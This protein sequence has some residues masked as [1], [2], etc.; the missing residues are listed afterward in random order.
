M[1]AAVEL[2][3]ATNGHRYPP[4]VI[5]HAM[6]KDAPWMLALK[7]LQPKIYSGAHADLER[8]SQRASDPFVED[9]GYPTVPRSAAGIEDE[10][11]DERH[12]KD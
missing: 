6:I 4:D 12:G 2:V 1:S 10:M 11:R 9:L 8:R 3:S 5:Q 7:Q